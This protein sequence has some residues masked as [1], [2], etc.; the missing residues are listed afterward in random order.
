MIDH[1]AEVL[2]ERRA[3]LDA[4][5]I[6]RAAARLG[7]E[8]EPRSSDGALASFGLQGGELIL[9]MVDAPHPALDALA[10][11]PLAIEPDRI[12]HASAHV[13]VALRDHPGGVRERDLVL[14]LAAGAV[15]DATGGLSVMLAPNVV[16]HR[17]ELFRDFLELARAEAA[18]PLELA[19][20]IT[21]APEEDARM[22]FLTH[23]LERAGSEEL[24][25][26]CSV[27]GRG[28]LDF[29]LGVAR[30]FYSQPEL[31]LP[32]GDTLGRSETEKILIQRV[33]SPI[34]PSQTVVRLDLDVDEALA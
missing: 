20:D 25:V 13:L 23:G 8:L 21:V 34:D 2:L 22:S 19:I 12:A 33:P 17:P 4:H 5:A 26:T 6:A 11:G 28:A 7:L 18:L 24:F 32:T 14:A 3:P 1:L 31:R 29:V 15:L 30:W 10:S 16:F 27:E 9:T